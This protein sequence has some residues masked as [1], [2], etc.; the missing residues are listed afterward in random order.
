M[1][2]ERDGTDRAGREVRDYVGGDQGADTRRGERTKRWRKSPRGKE[3]R[4][5]VRWGRS[6]GKGGMEGAVKG[7]V[8]AAESGNK[9]S[10]VV[11]GWGTEDRERPWC[12]VHTHPRPLR[13]GWI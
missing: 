13:A 1:I 11:A 5:S 3:R 9:K 10:R 7:A 8:K 4:G 6:R 12:V 2:E